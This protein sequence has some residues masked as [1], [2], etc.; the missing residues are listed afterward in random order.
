MIAKPLLL[1]RDHRTWLDKREGG[2]PAG[3]QTGQPGPKQPVGGMGV[4][5][6]KLHDALTGSI[7]PG[8]DNG[9]RFLYI[10]GDTCGMLTPRR[11]CAAT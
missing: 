4:E 3:P 11:V 10:C 6:E 7:Y 1:P 9:A 8:V 2:L 5:V